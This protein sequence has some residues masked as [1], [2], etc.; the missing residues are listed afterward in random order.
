[1]APKALE[2]VQQKAQELRGDATVIDKAAKKWHVPNTILWG[3][4]GIESA[5]GT[6][7]GPSS[8]GAMGPFQ[9][10][11][12]TGKQYGLDSNNINQLAPSADAAAHYLHDLFARTGSWD[13]ALRAYSGGGYG[14]SEVQKQAAHGKVQ[15]PSTGRL[16]DINVPDPLKGLE[17]V[18]AA[19]KDIA[20]A[21]QATTDF[22]IHP[23]RLL[24]LILG[25]IVLLWGI[26]QLSKNMGGPRPLRGATRAARR[27]TPAGRVTQ[28]TKAGRIQS[29]R[30]KIKD[31]GG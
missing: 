11:P 16:Q 14:L 5:Y 7:L 15:L 9:F 26:S 19:L 23:K 18:A 24:K 21:V 1:M 12:S 13:K 3:V 30:P 20:G 17:A 2:K 25:S 6:N 4:F 8:A 28:V 27:A 10:L 31:V 22:L 29:A